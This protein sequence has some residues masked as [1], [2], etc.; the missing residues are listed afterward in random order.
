MW[1]RLSTAFLAAA[2]LVS[3]LV[4]YLSGEKT[5]TA[6]LPDTETPQNQQS[7]IAGLSSSEALALLSGYGLVTGPEDAEWRVVAEQ[8]GI[9]FDSRTDD[10]TGIAITK[11]GISE[12]D[13]QRIALLFEPLG[14]LE[15]IYLQDASGI[16]TL[17][18]LADS[19][20]KTLRFA[21]GARELKDITALAGL[22]LTKFEIGSPDPELD[23]SALA[24]T[25]LTAFQSR[26][27]E[28]LPDISWISDLPIT[29][30]TL[31]ASTLPDLSAL[32]GLPLEMVKLEATEGS[33][34]LGILRDAPVWNLIAIAPSFDGLSSLTDMQLKSVGL[35]GGGEV[36]VTFLAGSPVND[37][38][39]AEMGKLE[40][41]SALSGAPISQLTLRDIDHIADLDVLRDRKG[42]IS[43]KL[44]NLP[45]VADLGFLP[46]ENDRDL[47]LTLQGLPVSDLSPLQ[48]LKVRYL[49]LE[50]L[51]QVRDLTALSDLPLQILHL[52][53]LGQV[54]DLSPITGSGI[55]DLTLRHM[56]EGLDL[57]PLRSL[58][59][60][61]LRTDTAS[62]GSG[63]EALQGMDI[64][65]RTSDPELEA[66]WEAL[67]E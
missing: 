15:N 12:E 4:I 18:A 39:F 27:D 52:S 20:L 10:Q 45:S 65:L 55:S 41:L 8:D 54:S 13:L 50:N 67:R 56:K 63:L 9:E 47:S 44:Q 29:D 38:R 58:P 6:P 36:D 1:L 42:L 53:R 32:E 11:S 25:Q 14:G 48:D 19:P 40:G 51:D 7:D 62:A 59:L 2:L 3:G 33:I 66:K 49:N 16:V 35:I 24:K 26:S 60:K 17:D 30:L 23:L 22:A 57:S 46:D 37:L 34:D 31:T 64:D 5:N 43:L 28:A 21:T 61:V